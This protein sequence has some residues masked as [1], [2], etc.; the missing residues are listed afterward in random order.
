MR[1][2]N[3]FNSMTTTASGQAGGPLQTGA[4]DFFSARITGLCCLAVSAV[5][6]GVMAA[7]AAQESG[8][9]WPQAYVVH[10][11]EASGVLALRT[12]YYMVEH[13]LRRGGAIRRITLTHGRATNLL[14]RPVETVVRDE[15]G[16]VLSDLN[17]SA[18][19]VTHRRA[20]L[21]EIVTVESVLADQNG[22]SSGVRAKTTLEYRWGY[23][24]IRKELLAPADGIRVRELCVVS[25][26]LA[27]SLTDYGYREGLTEEDGAPPFSFGSNRWGKWRPG[28]P[29]VRP[30]ETRF[31]PRSMIFADPGVEGLEWF[32]GSDLTQWDLQL[33]GR[34]GQ[35]R[36]VLA[37]SQ[38]SPGLALSLSPLWTTNAPLAL[39]D[40][41]TFD[42]YLAVPLLEGH[43]LKPWLHTSFNRNRGGWVTAE[44]IRQWADKGIQTVHCH[45]D[46]DYYNDGLFWRDGAYPP[47]PDMERYNEV[48]QECRRAGLRTATYFSNKEL[49][50]S[51]KEFQEQGA[52]WARKDRQGRL[53][54]N[55]FRGTNEFGAQMCLRSGWLEF[56]KFS[57]DRVLRNHP[58]DGVYYD[59]NVALF[60]CN[61]R[62]ETAAGGIAGAKG[63]WDVDELL[64]LME[65]TRQRVGPRGLIIV[66]NTTTPMFAAEN[67]ADHVV[68]TEWGY[69]K[70]TDRA[71]DLEELP[72]EW[73]LAG[74]RSRG[75]ISYGTIDSKAPRRIHRLF[76]LQALLGG[77]TPWPASP[78]AFELRPLLNPLG[79]VESY[80]FADWRNQAVTLSDR[81]CAS[82]IYSG[83]GEAY[84]LLAN[85]EQGPRE[86][87][88]VLHPER[89]P[90][91]L[92]RQ[93]AAARVDASATSRG[94]PD[95][96]P[97]ASLDVRQLIGQGLR[98][99]IPGDDAIL[100]RIRQ[101]LSDQPGR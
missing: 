97:P 80:R 61:P 34:R 21:N 16:A 94:S 62:H 2:L 68:A 17:D 64:D 85:L 28:Q 55:F 49:H 89:L 82:A 83:P 40:S 25:T 93:L 98:I 79:D 47:Y 42:F 33:A 14:M 53:Q 4:T 8:S 11:D 81:R 95:P 69:K 72:L 20:G 18:P 30:L 100:M 32:V 13:D 3:R 5:S 65:W 50:P 27:P 92:G 46:G 26:V 19:K 87:N 54:H 88:C 101:P 48:L 75:V 44:E 31:V 6:Q 35:G 77:V 23:V 90:H 66:H 96:T 9:T 60:C 58:L 74:A 36:C 12:P 45:N 29:S 57:I 24:R 7:S 70:W 1:D 76:A 71:P 15:A 59:W 56:L 51:T 73:S 22:R 63:H 41:C 78:E 39:K 43:A 67:F 38:D 84:L 52:V 91:P 10:R 86:V 99:V 37:R